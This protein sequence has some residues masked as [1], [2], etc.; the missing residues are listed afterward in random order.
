[1]EQIAG[2][3]REGSRPLTYTGRA[4]NTDGPT[5]RQTQNKQKY[6]GLNSQPSADSTLYFLGG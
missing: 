2:D 4:T 3:S 1:M 6:L 5:E